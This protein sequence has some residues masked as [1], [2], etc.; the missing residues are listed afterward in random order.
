MPKWRSAQFSNEIK[1]RSPSTSVLQKFTVEIKDKGDMN[2]I[3]IYS[4]YAKLFCALSIKKKFY[5][6][7]VSIAVNNVTSPL[8]E[9]INWDLPVRLI[10]NT[11]K[12]ILR[13][14][15]LPPPKI[16]RF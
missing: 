7:G 12:R 9:K 4:E 11:I 16:S 10:T 14:K 6:F 8:R 1:T 5:L 2:E 13:E 15:N 3:L